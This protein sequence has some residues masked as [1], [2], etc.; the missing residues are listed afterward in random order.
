MYLTDSLGSGFGKRSHQY[1][2]YQTYPVVQLFHIVGPGPL[3]FSWQACQPQVPTCFPHIPL[4]P[5]GA[6]GCL[7]RFDQDRGVLRG[8]FVSISVMHL[9]SVGQAY[10][11]NPNEKE[12]L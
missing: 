5:L 10:A 7:F 8:W 9:D 12:P 4:Q 11:L 3:A 6:G 2:P 1:L